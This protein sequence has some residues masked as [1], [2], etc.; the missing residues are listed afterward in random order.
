[1]ATRILASVLLA[2]LAS[3]AV[4]AYGGWTSVGDVEMSASGYAAIAAGVIL[5]LLVGCGLMALIFYSHRHGYDE[6]PQLVQ[7]RGEP[8]RQDAAPRGQP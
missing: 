6:P 1:M 4:M 2:L 3:A 8:E 5:S 7:D